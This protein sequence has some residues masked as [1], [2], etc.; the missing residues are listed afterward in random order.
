[1]VRL[2]VGDL[3]LIGITVQNVSCAGK[4]GATTARKQLQSASKTMTKLDILS[5]YYI[6]LNPLDIYD[7]PISFELK[8]LGFIK[9]SEKL[10]KNGIICLNQVLTSDDKTFKLKNTNIPHVILSQNRINSLFGDPFRVE[11]QKGDKIGEIIIL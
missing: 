7:F 4:L 8:E 6:K 1:M 5:P 2:T 10:L 9:L 11:I 3:I